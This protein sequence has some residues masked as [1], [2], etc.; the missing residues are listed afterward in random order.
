MRNAA[1]ALCAEL[2]HDDADAVCTGYRH[3]PQDQLRARRRYGL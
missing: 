2:D 1:R 3:A